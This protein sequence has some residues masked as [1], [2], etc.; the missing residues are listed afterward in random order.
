MTLSIG[1]DIGGTNL[2]VGVVQQTTILYETRFPADFSSLCKQYPPQVAWQEILRLTVGAVQ[3]A[4]LEHPEVSAIGIGFPGFID[5]VSGLIAQSPNLPGLRN[6]NL[7]GGLAE[8][9]QLPVVVENDA[10]VAAYGEYLLQGEPGKSLAYIGLGTGVGG[11]LIHGGRPFTG[12]HGIA[13]EV[14]HLIVDPGGRPCGCGNQGCLEQYASA[15]G[16]TISYEKLSGEYLST[17]KIAELAS[18]GDELALQSFKLAGSSLAIVVA[19]LIKILDVQN[20]L[21]GGGLSQAW[22]YMQDAFQHQL[23]HD[24]IPALKEKSNILISQSGDQ[25]GIIGAA[26]L[27]SQA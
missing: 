14:G 6:V 24:L 3:E 17:T 19:H 11:G 5:P 27:A 20:I 16:V 15:P 18:K 26:Y 10:L 2:R 22:E 12:D 25:A 9:L 13:M 8:Q 1:V 23:D 7:A 21:L 4:I